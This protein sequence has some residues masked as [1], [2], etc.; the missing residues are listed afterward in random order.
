MTGFLAG[1][2]QGN[3]LED[4]SCGNKGFWTG[5]LERFLERAAGS[6]SD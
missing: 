2:V 5:R 6:Q 4:L 1:A 3:M